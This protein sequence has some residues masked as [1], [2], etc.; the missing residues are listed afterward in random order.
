MK[1]TVSGHVQLVQSF[2]GIL[3]LN[4][5]KIYATNGIELFYDKTK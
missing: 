3:T 2:L 5:Q 1:L 4:A